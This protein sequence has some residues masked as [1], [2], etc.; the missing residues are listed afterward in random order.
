MLIN[1]RS[2]ASSRAAAI[3]ALVAPARHR[4][5]GGWWVTTNTGNYGSAGFAG[6]G[7][8]QTNVRGKSTKL[9]TNRPPDL[10]V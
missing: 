8:N 6:M 7:S 5:P 1:Q 4:V 9:R 2:F 10:F 3:P